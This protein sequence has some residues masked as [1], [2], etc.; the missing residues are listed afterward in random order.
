MNCLLG[1]LVAKCRL[2]GKIRW[3]R[4]TLLDKRPHCAAPFGHFYLEL[5]KKRLYYNAVNKELPWGHHLW[6]AGQ[7]ELVSVSNW[8]D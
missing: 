5:G 8:E 1:A 7:Y 4:S 2:G 6:F 3:R